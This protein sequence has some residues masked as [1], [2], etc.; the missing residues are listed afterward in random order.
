MELPELRHAAT[1]IFES[2][3][4]SVDPGEAVRRNV[5]VHDSELAVVDSR[6]DLATSSSG[7]YAIAIGKA[8]LPMAIA[9]EDVLGKHL[10]EGLL[11]G[12]AIRHPDLELRSSVQRKL[13]TS[14]RWC[15]GGHPLPNK[16]SLL[17]AEESFGLLERANAQQAPVIFLISGGGSAMIEWPRNKEITLNDLR[18]ANRLLVSCGATIAEINAVRRAYS[19]VKGGG[20]VQRASRCD[21][22]TLI[23]SDTNPGDEAA[24]ASGPTIPS[25]ADVPSARDVVARYPMLADLPASI[26][27]TI[28]AKS[29]S[30][31]TQSEP[32]GEQASQETKLREHYVLLSNRTALEAAAEAARQQGFKTEIAHDVVEQRVGEG[33]Q[34]LLARLDKLRRTAS[35]HETVCLI[36]GGEFGCPVK[37]NGIGGRNAESVLRCAIEIEAANLPQ[38]EQHREPHTLVLSAGTDGIDG[39][40]PAAGAF[41]DETTVARARASDLD[42]KAFL[43]NSNA[44]AFFDKLGDTLIT[45]RTGTNVRDLR[46]LLARGSG[47]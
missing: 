35:N 33:C 7:I 46:I 8:A 13:S 14:W 1:Q 34:L 27:A 6:L 15:E 45:G 39:N 43:N 42:A 36:S 44:F 3:L 30:V 21:Q 4:R 47:N 5:Q 17:A 23:I 38:D 12:P 29:P 11:I 19:A 31:T 40:S 10:R 22:V 37:G 41:A 26:L 20:L 2:A 18:M 32:A 24:V 25:H 28:P 9:V 16:A